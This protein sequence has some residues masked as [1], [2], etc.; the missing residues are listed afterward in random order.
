MIRYKKKKKVVIKKEVTNF[1]FLKL[2]HG[3]SSK[4]TLKKGIVCHQ[5]LIL[6]KGMMWYYGFQHTKVVCVLF[7][8]MCDVFYGQ[9]NGDNG[10][11]AT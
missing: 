4:L 10:K 6:K 7:R 3:L 5:K 9:V 2:Y 11:G 1:C 8:K